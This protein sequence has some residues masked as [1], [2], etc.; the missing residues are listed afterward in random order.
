MEQK[1]LSVYGNSLPEKAVQ[2]AERV[3]QSYASRF[4]YDPSWKPRLVAREMPGAWER[5]G[6]RQLV[7]EGEDFSSAGYYLRPGGSMND[8]PESL[9]RPRD[10]AVVIGTIRMGFGHY[11]IAVAI[12]SA[13]K[14]MGLSPYLL[15]FLAFPDSAASRTIT[16][17][18]GL[19]SF[20]SRLAEKFRLFNR[21]VWEPFTA[22]AA[23]K[24]S[25]CARDLKLAEIYAPLVGDLSRATPF[26]ATHPWTGQAAVRAGM[27]R[28][29][30]VVPDN[31]PL[32]F[33][34]VEGSIHA[35]QTPSNY[36]GYR[37]LR[38]M[39]EKRSELLVPIPADSVRYTGHFVDHELVSNIEVDCNRR[40]KRLR[41]GR[42][43]RLLLTMGGAGAQGH[44][45]YE[46]IRFCYPSI[47]TNRAVVFVNMGDHEDRWQELKAELEGR[48][49][50]YVLHDSWEETQHFAEEILD[51]ETYGI[52]IFL[53]RDIFAA[54]Y[55]TNLLM[56]GVELMVTKPSE[57]SFYP[58]PKLFIERVGR[59]EAWGA[60]RGAEIGD[61]TL[62]TSTLRGLQQTLKVILSDN[63]LLE[64]YCHNILNNKRAGIYDGAYRAVEIAVESMR[65]I[66][67]HD[68]ARETG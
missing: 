15:D 41:E 13:A 6:M 47:E 18:N 14:S 4:G 37:T 51:S 57:L 17:L 65:Q 3:L 43:K 23:L 59:H 5:F 30:T 28:V 29:V 46:I 40:L 9:P 26:L 2:K 1:V 62:E 60:I 63:D 10:P 45:F 16:Y 33:H 25:Y 21:F 20:A 55:T 48:R 66:S 64:L 67:Q 8:G 52:H 54:V 7:E 27:E 11:R 31:F 42:P 12:A 50:H 22:E 35:V 24:L 61:G 68:E 19:Y 56:R 36:L 44:R 34:L 32:A 49:I 38:N 39:G 58:V 53:N